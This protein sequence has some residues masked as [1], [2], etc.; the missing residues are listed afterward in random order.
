MDEILMRSTP[1]YRELRTELL[2][3]I[4]LLDTLIEGHRPTIFSETYLS[5][6]EVM[7]L[8]DLSVRTLQNYRDQRIIPYTTIGGK[9]LYPQS[10]IEKL[11]E[12]HYR[13]ALR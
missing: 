3:T 7:S 9:F 11:L 13:T 1:Q 2:K 6:E 12:G 8:F 5:A 4:R 10:G